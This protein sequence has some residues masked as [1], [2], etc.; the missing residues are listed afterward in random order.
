MC[1]RKTTIDS[2]KPP[3]E[4]H[5]PLPPGKHF[6]IRVLVL[7]P[8][9]TDDT[10]KCHL[11]V[12]TLRRLKNQFEAISYVWGDPAR[13]ADISCNGRVV[14]VTL[15]LAAALQQFRHRRRV[16]RLWADA[17]CINQSDDE[18]KGL[19]V[20][21]MGQIYKDAKR[22]LVWLGHD[23]QRQAY[24]TF[25]IMQW[26]NKR[27]DTEYVEHQRYPPAMPALRGSPLGIDKE[28]GPGLI[29]LIS[30][31]WFFRVWTV[32]ESALARDCQVYWGGFSMPIADVFEFAYWTTESTELADL[33]DTGRFQ[34]K[35]RNF[36]IMFENL[37]SH[38]RSRG[39]WHTSR[40]ALAFSGGRL[41]GNF[42]FSLMLFAGLSLDATDTRDHIYAFLGSRYA[43]NQAG[44]LLIQADYSISHTECYT[45]LARALLQDPQEGP[46]FLMCNAHTARDDVFYPRTDS[47]WIPD[48]G[49]RK[50]SVTKADPY[51]HYKAGGPTGTFEAVPLSQK[52]LELLGF[53]FDTVVYVSEPLAD[54]SGFRSSGA[55]EDGTP[56]ELAIDV[57][58]REVSAQSERLGLDLKHDAFLQTLFEGKLDAHYKLYNHV[59]DYENWRRVT[60]WERPE[61][62]ES[63]ADAPNSRQHMLAAWASSILKG[64]RGSSLILTEYGGVGFAKEGGPIRAGDVCCVVLGAHFPFIL[65]PVD[66]GRHRLVTECYIHGVMGGELVDKLDAYKI[67]LE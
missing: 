17:L 64:L 41:Y 33:T 10:L 4:V 49:K 11:E 18:E 30:H 58:W 9:N 59:D 45:T 67:V 47:S 22:V 3:R 60:T 61:A 27:L 57:L 19:Q 2:R 53:V 51:C 8:G 5:E 21:R 50:T 20:S 13:T 54:L 44:G 55:D 43:R 12:R 52:L 7:H 35:F 62:I 26:V 66:H 16:R 14:P 15:N 32:Q 65:A 48:W 29:A 38:Y 24:S 28:F 25:H 34:R 23:N 63:S 40:S 46:W 1:K 31:P 39:S 6:K 36:Y 56:K 42:C 37:H